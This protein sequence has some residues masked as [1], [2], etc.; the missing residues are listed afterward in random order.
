MYYD[1]QMVII[2]RML[3]MMM[4]MMIMMLNVLYLYM[5]FTMHKSGFHVSCIMY[6]YDVHNAE[7]RLP[8]S[9]PHV[10]CLSIKYI[11]QKSGFHTS[12]TMS[13]YDAYIFFCRPSPS[14]SVCSVQDGVSLACLPIYPSMMVGTPPVLY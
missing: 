12:S 9:R 3:M 7:M 2:K 10:Q 4:V 14:T 5:R 8:A 11:M 6:L 1:H 13:I